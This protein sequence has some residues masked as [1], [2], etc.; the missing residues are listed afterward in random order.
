MESAGTGAAR[1]AV[2]SP[3]FEVFKKMWM[4]HLG[5]QFRGEH[6]GGALLKVGLCDLTCLFQP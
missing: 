4:W 3:H 5:T 1:E 6:S 2:K